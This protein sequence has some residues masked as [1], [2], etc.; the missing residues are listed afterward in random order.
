MENITNIVEFDGEQKTDERKLAYIIPVQGDFAN[1]FTDTMGDILKGVALTKKDVQFIPTRIDDDWHTKCKLTQE[2][3]NTISEKFNLQPNDVVLFAYG[4]KT[5]VVSVAHS[6]K[7]YIQFT[8]EIIINNHITFHW[9][10]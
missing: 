4:S 6:L 9:E 8:H 10:I 1:A 2:S 3:A 5:D 7:S